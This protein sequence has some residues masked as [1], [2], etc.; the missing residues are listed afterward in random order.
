M[1]PLAANVALDQFFLEARCQLLTVAAIL[2][3]IDRGS[4]ADKATIDPRMKRIHRAIALLTS[5]TRDRAEQIQRLFSLEYDPEW[6][7][8]QPR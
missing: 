1:T 8:P 7:R 5:E 4:G 6:N 3:R 2:D